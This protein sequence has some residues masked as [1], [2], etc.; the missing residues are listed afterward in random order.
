[1]FNSLTD[2]LEAAFSK[3]SGRGKL[4]EGDVEEVLKEVRIALLEADVHT[5]VV[6]AF[7]EKIR[8]RAIGDEV[9]KALTPGQQVVK[10]VHEELI[11]ILGAEN[12]PLAVA[13]KAPTVIMMAGLQGSGKTTAAGK[14]ARLLRSRG[15]RPMLVACDLR[16]PAAIEQLQLLGE[17][18]GIPVYTRTDVSPVE[19]AAGGVEEAIRRKRD[20]VIIDTAGRLAIDEEMMAEAAA[21]RDR[22]EPHE[23]LFVIDSMTGQ[24]AVGVATAFL[25]RV[26]YS[27]IILSKLDGD[28]RGGAALSVAHVSGR[29]VKFASTGEQLDAFEAF[30]PDR[31]ASRI[32]GM[33]DMLTL[34]EKA[35]ETFA[36]GEQAELQE[37]MRKGEFTL[38]EFLDQMKRLR[39]M[40]SMTSLLGMIPGM[41]K[42]VEDLD[43][44]DRELAQVEAIIHSMTPAERR[45]PKIINNKRRQRIAR[46]CGRTVQDV[47]ML[48]RQFDQAK[49]M[50]RVAAGGGGMPSIPQM[51]RGGGMQ[52]GDGGAPHRP[53]TKRQ[54]QAKTHGKNKK[55]KRK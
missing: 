33:G 25:E 52:M 50:M 45:D 47:N 23:T 9:S 19:V 24:D 26:D 20:T 42:H 32:L 2:R 48:L 22:V 30:H 8:E 31:M 11:A 18:V 36:E 3:L 21:I 13:P 29:P 38:E 6:R 35:E 5:S 28:A 51:M 39:K 14:L 12:V 17:Q 53:K 16:R 27:G 46:G 1:M 55:K 41:R 49:V 15:K 34:I 44:D 54:K 10:I 4:S 43:I 7:I 37:K 40:G